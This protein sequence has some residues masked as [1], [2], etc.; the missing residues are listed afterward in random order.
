MITVR[1]I[2]FDDPLH[3][4]AVRLREEV[5]LAPIGLDG[6]RFRAMFPE[7]GAR[8]EHFEHFIAVFDHPSGP[9]VIGTALLLPNY[10]T[11]GVGK[12][13]QMAVDLQRQGEG[14][15]TRLVVAIEQRA[16][17][18]LGMEEIFCHARDTAYGFYR[19]LGWDFDSEVFQEAGVP[20]RRMRFRPEAGPIGEP[21]EPIPDE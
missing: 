13:M 21:E 8:E 20:H 17:G 12:L 2:S 5:L 4:Q 3:A 1:R 6:P 19:S 14:V 15:G 18:Q 16:F 10:P 7:G 11:R 9:R